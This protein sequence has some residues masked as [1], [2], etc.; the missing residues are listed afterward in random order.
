MVNLNQ[1]NVI[2]ISGIIGSGKSYISNKIKEKYQ[3]NLIE[4]DDVRRY[5][6]WKSTDNLAYELREQLNIYFKLNYDNLMFHRK[7]FSDFIFSEQN[8]LDDFNLICV[9]YFKSYIQS[10]L[11][12]NQL[13]LITWVNLVE[14]NYVDLLDYIIFVDVSEK[15]WKQRNFFDI[16]NIKKR[17][18]KQKSLNEKIQQ[19]NNRLPYEVF[20]NE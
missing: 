6:L 20:L 4:I 2:G 8:I 9:P 14:D 11:L 3:A 15:T 13:N 12:T 17:L 10:Q 16:D 7:E 1:F 5:L 18:D 19:L